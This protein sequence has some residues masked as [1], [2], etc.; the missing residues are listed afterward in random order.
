ML[1]LHKTLCK[2]LIS[3][4]T[5]HLHS[6]EEAGQQLNNM[7]NNYRVYLSFVTPQCQRILLTFDLLN[8]LSVSHSPL[9]ARCCSPY[10]HPLCACAWLLLYTSLIITKTTHQL[11]SS[12]IFF[13]FI[14]L[15]P[16][17][18]INDVQRVFASGF[19]VQTTTTHRV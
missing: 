11:C 6:R 14:F 17:S 12:S 18:M 5:I 16:N 8:S 4:F 15:I 2:K 7:V 1:Y 13:C 19:F 3:A 9:A 10:S